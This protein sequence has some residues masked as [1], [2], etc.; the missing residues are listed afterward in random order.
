MVLEIDDNPELSLEI[1]KV[2]IDHATGHERTH[3]T[4]FLTVNRAQIYIAVL[5]W[6]QVKKE[7]APALAENKIN[8]R[9]G[10]VDFL[11]PAEWLIINEDGIYH[12]LGVGSA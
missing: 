11:A 2:Y 7:Y 6:S 4:V 5:I 8:F 12:S 10:T 3:S 9:F 1:V